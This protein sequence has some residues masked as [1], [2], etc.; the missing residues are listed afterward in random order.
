MKIPIRMKRQNSNPKSGPDE[1]LADKNSAGPGAENPAGDAGEDFLPS[2]DQNTGGAG[3]EN[4]D[5]SGAAI[6]DGGEVIPETEADPRRV[7]SG[8]G[9]GAGAAPTE[10]VR[11]AVAERDQLLD[12]LARLQAEFDNYRKRSQ[13]EQAEFK[14]YAST[15]VVRALLPVIDNFELALKTQAKEGDFRTGIELIR[16]QLY[17]V[18]AKLGLEAIPAKGEMFDP[19]VHEGIEMVETDEAPDNTV[20]EELQPGYRFKDRM[21]RPAMVRVA[22]NGGH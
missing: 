9:V 14:Q 1:P 6:T 11:K 20:L 19:H 10:A 12:R 4:G 21:L 13:R 15:E 8:A 22:R 17:D 5:A 16:K 3:R 18:L 2:A 7:P